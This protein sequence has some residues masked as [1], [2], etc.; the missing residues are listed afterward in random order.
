[1]IPIT[2]QGHITNILANLTS[3]QVNDLQTQLNDMDANS[4]PLILGILG[5]ILAPEISR[6]RDIRYKVSGY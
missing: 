2:A 3:S 1:M 6:Y 4:L 5:P